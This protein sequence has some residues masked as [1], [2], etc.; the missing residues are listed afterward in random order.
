M[1]TDV[2]TVAERAYERLCTGFTTGAW[3][4]FFDMVADEVDFGWPVEPGAGRFSGSEGRRLLEQQ[5]RVFVGDV[6]LTDIRRTATTEAGDTVIFEDE[7]RG[8]LGGT[9]YHARH[10]VFLTVGGGRILGFREYIAQEPAD[11]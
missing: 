3:D 8:D 1:D 6:R 10:C 9:P 2:V 5:L 11:T 7:S 4:P